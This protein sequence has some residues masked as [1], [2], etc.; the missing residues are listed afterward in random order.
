MVGRLVKCRLRVYFFLDRFSNHPLILQSYCD[1]RP[2]RYFFKT[3]PEAY[4][5]PAGDASVI[6]LVQSWKPTKTTLENPEEA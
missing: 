2:L 4:N 1:I 3:K 5:K 6:L